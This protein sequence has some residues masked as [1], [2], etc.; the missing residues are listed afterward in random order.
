MRQ[1]FGDIYQTLGMCH[2]QIMNKAS[3]GQKKIAA[4]NLKSMLAIFT[5][6]LDNIIG[7]GQ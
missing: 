7:K 2:E 3:E 5:V 1:D 4:L 6:E